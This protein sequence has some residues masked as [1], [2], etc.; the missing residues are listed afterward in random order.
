MFYYRDINWYEMVN[1]MNNTQQQFNEMKEKISNTIQPVFT[2][3]DDRIMM[4]DDVDNRKTP[5]EKLAYF[6][7]G[8]ITLLTPV[9]FYYIFGF[10]PEIS[11]PPIRIFLTIVNAILTL[12]F[13]P[14]LR[15]L[16]ISVIET[17]VTLCWKYPKQVA[18][19]C[20]FVLLLY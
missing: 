3:F 9:Y 20:I 8:I 15:D 1:D 16:Y 17:L 12:I 13:F 10:I 5:F 7:I 14:N 19:I 11:I 6:I 18:V 2:L 4:F